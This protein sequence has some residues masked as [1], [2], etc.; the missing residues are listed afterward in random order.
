MPL[1]STLIMWINSNINLCLYLFALLLIV[2]DR[3]RSKLLS[4]VIIFRWLAAVY[5]GGTYLYA[6]FLHSRLDGFS[7]PF[8]NLSVHSP[9]FE[10]AILDICFAILAIAAFKARYGYRIVIAV[11][12]AFIGWIDVGVHVW[13][14]VQLHPGQSDGNILLYIPLSLWFD[15]LVPLM[16]LSCLPKMQ[17]K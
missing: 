9:Y 6:F 12:S 7:Y 8:I 10:I 3:S 13:E 4:E 5:L 1:L 2:L 17:H 16:L 11:T 14:I 15:F